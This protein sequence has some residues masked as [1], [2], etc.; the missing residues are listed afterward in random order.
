MVVIVEAKIKSGS[1]ITADYALEQGKDIYAVPGRM[2]DALSEGCNNLIR[3]GAGIISDV[4]EFLKELELQGEI[5]TGED[6]LKNLLL[7]KSVISQF[8]KQYDISFVE[9]NN[10]INLL[11]KNVVVNISDAKYE[12][13]NSNIKFRL[14]TDYCINGFAFREGLEKNCY[15]SALSR[16]PEILYEI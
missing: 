11:Y 3:Q 7:K 13:F 16:G 15:Y 8:F 12:D 1:L 9:N 10:N 14:E 6:N 4:D 2:Y 5:N